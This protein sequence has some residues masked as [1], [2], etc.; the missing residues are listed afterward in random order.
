[1][2]VFSPVRTQYRE[3]QLVLAQAKEAGDLRT[4]LRAVDAAGRVLGLQAR[5]FAKLD[6]EMQSSKQ[7]A[8]GIG[9]ICWIGNDGK[10]IAET[11]EPP[12]IADGDERSYIGVLR[13]ARVF[14][15]AQQEGHVVTLTCPKPT[16]GKHQEAVS[17]AAVLGASS[18]S[19]S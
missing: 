11:F 5:L 10:F 9:Y 2:T 8:G 13:R 18:R 17:C 16:S 4:A 7:T 19:A 1:V 15:K 14:A 12:F 6:E 3:T